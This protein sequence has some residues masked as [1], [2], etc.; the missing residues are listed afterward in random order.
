MSIKEQRFFLIA[1]SFFY[2]KGVENGRQFAL[3]CL[4]VKVRKK[5]EKCV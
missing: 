1:H 5:P 4:L 2:W 3:S